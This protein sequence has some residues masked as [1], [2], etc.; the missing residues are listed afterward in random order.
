MVFPE[1]TSWSYYRPVP[2][3]S[4]L[5]LFDARGR[6]QVFSLE[7]AADF[8]AFEATPGDAFL[9]LQ[10]LLLSIEPGEL[11]GDGLVDLLV[12]DVDGQVA[13]HLLRTVPLIE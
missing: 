6:V 9:P 12:Q 11:T 7:G 10:G 8:N 4:R 2:P 3:V 13:P 5:A 1:A